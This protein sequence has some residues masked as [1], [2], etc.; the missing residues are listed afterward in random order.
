MLSDRG[1]VPTVVKIKERLKYKKATNNY[2]KLKS[3]TDDAYEFQSDQKKGKDILISI[4]VPVFNPKASH[5]RAMIESVIFQSYGNWELCIADASN[6]KGDIVGKVVRGC[7]DKRIKY[8]KLDKNYGIAQNSNIAIEMASGSYVILLDHDDMLS[9]DALY[10][11]KAP[12]NRGIDVIYS[13]EASFS[14]S[15]AHPDIIHFKPA[16][17]PFNLLGNNYICHLCCFRKELFNRVGGFREGFDGSQDHDLM[18]RMCEEAQTVIN[19]PKVLYYWRMHSG[20]V[21]TDISAKPYCIE[22]GLKAV[23][24]K[25]ESDGIQAQ[26]Q[27]I[28][29]AP[30]YKVT[31]NCDIKPKVVRK[32]GNMEKVTDE[33]IIYAKKGIKLTKECVNELMQYLQ[34]GN[35][36]VVCPMAIAGNRIQGAGLTVGHGKVTNAC[37][38]THISSDG[39]MH[40][41]KYAHNVT[42]A[43]DYCFAIRASVIKRAGGF[44]TTLGEAESIIDM[45]LRLREFGY[46]TVLNPYAIVRHRLK[47]ELPLSK[48]FRSKW[49]RKLAKKDKWLREEIF[50]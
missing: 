10:E 41:L 29:G 43:G 17:S 12:I 32:L 8:K 7:D 15:K 35:V 4:C 3:L 37:H 34:L 14:S 50:G 23:Q 25:L 24:A 21:A 46:S 6:M 39:Y 2:I 22:S 5:F 18:L 38:N 40:I 20:S 11:L 33:Y 19:I 44:D 31:Y 1:L 49:K 16:Y 42:S 28:N 26:A 30:V 48:L 9:L 47:K 13:D 45:C 27:S 36:G